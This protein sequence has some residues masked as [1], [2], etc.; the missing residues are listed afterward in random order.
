M[1]IAKT[2]LPPYYDKKYHLFGRRHNL[3]MYSISE[4]SKHC[5]KESC[6]IV[7]NGLVFDVTEFLPFH[8]ASSECILNNSGG[9]DCER[10]FKFHSKNAQKLLYK[11]IIGRV[12]KQN[13]IDCVIQ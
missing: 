13:V 9:V 2:K 7:V 11:F 6:W 5:N 4:I 3:P 12:E 1:K 10:H 8:P